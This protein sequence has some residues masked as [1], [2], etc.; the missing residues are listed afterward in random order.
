MAYLHSVITIHI[1]FY[2][3]LLDGK[4]VGI[5]ENDL[6]SKLSNNENSMM[7]TKNKARNFV[8]DRNK[9]QNPLHNKGRIL[10]L[11]INKS[12]NPVLGMDKREDPALDT[13]KRQNTL[14]DI[15]KRQNP[16]MDRDEHEDMRSGPYR[17][18]C[19]T[20]G[21][22]E[23]TKLKP[24]PRTSRTFLDN[25]IYIGFTLYKDDNVKIDNNTGIFHFV[26]VD[27]LGNRTG[28]E[29]DTNHAYAY[30]YFY[31]RCPERSSGVVAAGYCLQT[32]GRWRFKSAT[33]NSRDGN[34]NMSSNYVDKTYYRGND[35]EMHRREQKIL[36]YCYDKW[37][38][39]S[40]SSTFSCDVPEATIPSSRTRPRT[41][42]LVNSNT[43]SHCACETHHG[44]NANKLIP[45][46]WHLCIFL[47]FIYTSGIS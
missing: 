41:R 35:R 24:H 7:D 33:F 16:V 32:L 44:S 27:E 34:V 19:Q 25:K 22:M 36:T 20:G 1:V 42:S 23:V 5:G 43:L 29:V 6:K 13:D 21:Y 40:F 17:I 14:S 28:C 45:D 47:H 11:D 37:K 30:R 46:Y 38:R 18:Q 12:Q 9:I 2:Y 8:L 39:S 10:V 26:S 4:Y 3:L 31:N 15:D